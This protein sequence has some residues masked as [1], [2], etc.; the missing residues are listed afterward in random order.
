MVVIP[1]SV[2]PKRIGENLKATQLKLNAEE[3]ERIRAIDKP[4]DRVFKVL[5][6]SIYHNN[7]YYYT[8]IN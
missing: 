1:K 2:N 3:M 4:G 7:Y 6:T 5:H 8:C